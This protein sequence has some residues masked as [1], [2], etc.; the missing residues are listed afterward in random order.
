MCISCVPPRCVCIVQNVPPIP[1]N[2]V[3]EG[4]PAGVE[5]FTQPTAFARFALS[6]REDPSLRK[7][8]PHLNGWK[9][10]VLW[11][12]PKGRKKEALFKV[13]QAA[14]KAITAEN[15]GEGAPPNAEKKLMMA[16]GS[17][18]L[19]VI[20]NGAAYYW[21]PHTNEVQVE[22]PSG[23]LG[24]ELVVKKPGSESIADSPSSKTPCS[25]SKS[26]RG[27]G[28]GKTGSSKKSADSEP[29][30]LDMCEEWSE[31]QLER[32]LRHTLNHS[33]TPMREP[34][35]TRVKGMI[36]A[37]H[38]IKRRRAQANGLAHYDL[39][40]QAEQLEIDCMIESLDL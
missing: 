9:D 8:S 7:Y 26:K 1:P 5:Y 11:K 12:D 39:D 2:G 38:T 37:L 22:P 30:I 15:G 25:K 29:D 23:F 3:Y 28:R 36:A 31:E 33:G 35:P 17:Q 14:D 16:P 6:L 13:R 32:W 10:V 40:A 24:T 19:K 27:K 21:Q 20:E 34:V 18:W 4:R